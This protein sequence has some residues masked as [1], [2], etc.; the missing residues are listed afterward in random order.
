[1]E[2]LELSGGKVIQLPATHEEAFASTRNW[3]DWDRMYG[4]QYL[5]PSLL[6]FSKERVKQYARITEQAY[7]LFQKALRYTQQ[8]IP[9]AYLIHQLGV[10]EPLVHAARK[11]VPIDAITRFDLAICGDD[12]FILEYNA[13]TPT[14][15]VETAYVAESVIRRYS[16]YQNP[17]GHM[18]ETI[19]HAIQQSIKYYRSE[20]FD[21]KIVFSAT[22]H[23]NEDI[24][25][26][27]YAQVMSEV[28]SIYTHLEDLRLRPDG[29]YTN[30]ERASIWYRLYPWEHLPHDQ[31]I[32]GFPVGKALI[33]CLNEERL[34]TISPVQSIITQSKGFQALLWELAELRHPLFDEADLAFMM[35]HMLPSFLESSPFTSKGIPFVS[36]P[37]F[38]REGG[39]VTLYDAAG[40]IDESDQ[41]EHYWEQPS[42]YQ[43]RVDL[44][45]L[46]IQT[47]EG[48]V[49]GYL[50]LGAFCIG[51]KFGGLLPRVGGRITGNLAY[52]MAAA[53]E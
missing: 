6:V 5:V 46:R 25:T 49:D 38:G 52:F 24:G 16:T 27:Q 51:G 30:E 26:V 36:K 39:A 29:L 34:A 28:D 7:Q 53:M 13:D 45:Q 42:I 21:G 17:S 20:G 33:E 35:K 48:E 50:L 12:V 43:Q 37:L 19:K 47:D 40:K 9:D 23:S 4:K 41:S 1:M 22:K 14:G 31:D 2:A 8:Y 11:Y 44:Q 32:D 18:N 10:P 15:V 3:C